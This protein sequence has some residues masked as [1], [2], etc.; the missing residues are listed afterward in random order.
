MI[1]DDAMEVSYSV[2]YLPWLCVRT[3]EGQTWVD[4]H[5][6]EHCGKPCPKPHYWGYSGDAVARLCMARS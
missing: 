5:V 3:V 1:T 6:V 2:N 4:P